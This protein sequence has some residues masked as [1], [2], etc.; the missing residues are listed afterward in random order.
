VIGTQIGRTR[1]RRR[2]DAPADAV[3]P[4]AS[5]HGPGLRGGGVQVLLRACL[6]TFLLAVLIF[7]P[8]GTNR[9]A[10]WGVVL[11]YA[12]GSAVLGALLNPRHRGGLGWLWLAPFLDVAVLVTLALLVDQVGASSWTATLLERG[13]FLIPALAATLLNVRLVAAVTAPTVAVYL[14]TSLITGADDSEPLAS[15][16][17]RSGVLA[18]LSAGAVLM[19]VVQRARV[20]TITDLAAD[21]AALLAEMVDIEN[22]ERRGLA[23]D[24]HDGAL[25][26][27]LAARQDLESA[28]DGDAES[29]DRVDEALLASSRS[30]RSTV[31]GLHPAA[32]DAAGVTAVIKELTDQAGARGRLAARVDVS[33]W[34]TGRTT[35]DELL[36]MTARELLT[37]VVKH[38]AAST[39]LVTLRRD[40]HTAHLEVADDGQGIAGVDLGARL[41]E[42]HLGVA[43]RQIRIVAAG[44]EISF[45]AVHPHGT[46]VDVSVPLNP[47]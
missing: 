4:S 34:P 25:Q 2:L 22:R 12:A 41:A 20:Q 23:E 47:L 11:V 31:A 15:V 17:L 38:A 36:I 28:R 39:V 30:L 45:R 43:S 3:E 19:S 8:P 9:L 14:V 5:S 16:L 37:N 13:F 44:G 24:L 7:V 1:L 21:R 46:A 42:G 35:A 27:V 40:E 33:G 10:C 6:V 26:Y 29:F 18:G 32:V